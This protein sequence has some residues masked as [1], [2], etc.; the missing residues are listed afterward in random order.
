M[1]HSCEEFFRGRGGHDFV[2]KIGVFCRCDEAGYMCYCS[3]EN[4]FV[5]SEFGFAPSALGSSAG[6]LCFGNLGSEPRCRR[7]VG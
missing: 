1:I 2:S 6:T 3:V 7:A 4:V 5:N